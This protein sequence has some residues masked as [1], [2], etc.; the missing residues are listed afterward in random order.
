VGSNWLQCESYLRKVLL[1]M[2]L[3]HGREGIKI[4]IKRNNLSQVIKTLLGF[5]KKVLM[6]F[7]DAK[8]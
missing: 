3:K 4:K 1:E 5:V 7:K 2:M 8:D 6:C